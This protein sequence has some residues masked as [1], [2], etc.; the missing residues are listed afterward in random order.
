[1]KLVLALALTPA[2]IALTTYKQNQELPGTFFATPKVDILSAFE[3]CKKKKEGAIC[4]FY[5]NPHTD[6]SYRTNPSAVGIYRGQ[7]VYYGAD[8]DG[9]HLF[10]ADEASSDIM[11]DLMSETGLQESGGAGACAGFP[12]NNLESGAAIAY[13]TTVVWDEGETTHGNDSKYDD[14]TVTLISSTIILNEDLKTSDIRNPDCV[15]DKDNTSRKYRNDLDG[16]KV[17]QHIH[18]GDSETDGP[19]AIGFCGPFGPPS[20]PACVDVLVEPE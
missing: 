9:K 18:L 8:E 13:N 14:D 16:V 12:Y 2:V 5:I 10:V 1:M 17:G 15:T 19:P 3:D 4:G 6:Y 11:N 7:F 20:L